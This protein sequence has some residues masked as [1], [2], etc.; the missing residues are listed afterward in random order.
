MAVRSWWQAQ[1][2]E[3]GSQLPAWLW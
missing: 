3:S 2:R 1:C